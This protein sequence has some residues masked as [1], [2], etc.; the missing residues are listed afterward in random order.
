MPVTRSPW[1]WEVATLAN[2]QGGC[3]WLVFCSGHR[4]HTA[5]VM[6]QP[7]EGQEW[8]SWGMQTHGGWE[9]ESVYIEHRPATGGFLDSEPSPRHSGSAMPPAQAVNVVVSNQGHRCS[10]SSACFQGG[11]CCHC[12]CSLGQEEIKNSTQEL[13]QVRT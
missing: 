4:Q 7:K 2:G 10:P 12:S 3:G 5:S 13:G 8:G 6:S 11:F 1:G 9:E